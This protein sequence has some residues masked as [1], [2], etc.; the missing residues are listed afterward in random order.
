MA[1]QS[2]VISLSSLLREGPAALSAARLSM[3][4]WL[5]RQAHRG[6]RRRV[7]RAQVAMIGIDVID[8]MLHQTFD[9]LFWNVLP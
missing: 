6:H 4:P 5:L 7:S 8:G 1:L 3:L 9:K 2:P